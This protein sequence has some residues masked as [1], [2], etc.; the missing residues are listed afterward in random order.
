LEIASQPE[1]TEPTPQSAQPDEAAL[2]L[3]SVEY[4]GRWHRL[5]ST[6]N[7]EK[8]RIISLWRQALVQ[9]GAAV[10]VYSDEAWSRRVGNVTPQ[11][12]GRLRRVHE[13]FGVSYEQF[14]GLFWSHFQAALDWHDAEMWLEGAVQNGWSVA[15]MRSE[16][17]K[18]LG[19]T[20]EAEPVDETPEMDEDSELSAPQSVPQTLTESV[21]DVQAPADDGHEAP[22]D[23]DDAPFDDDPPFDAATAPEVATALA[24]VRPFENL[25][26]LPQDLADAVETFKLAILRHKVA[27][28][29]EVPCGEVVAALDALKQLAVAPPEA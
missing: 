20:P 12:V 19:G 26:E 6:T 1:N 28:W 18:A 13:Q 2:E 22:F 27:G 23:A 7:W 9:S 14:P 25:A 15:R 11:H 24:P 8:G 17:W 10:Q 3:T 4:L 29:Q 5:V 21:C 16:R